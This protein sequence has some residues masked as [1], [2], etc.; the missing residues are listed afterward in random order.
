MSGK[1]LIVGLTGGSGTGKSTVSRVFEREG[2][3]I[4]DYDLISRQVCEKGSDC[5]DEIC[6]IFG[7]G[8]L[9]SDSTLNRK[10]LGAIVFSDGEKL[11]ALN[12]ITH[13]YITLR[14]EE[15]LASSDS[16]RFVLDA[17]LLFEAELEKKCD[18][19]VSVLSGVEK[20]TERIMQRDSISYEYALK[21]INSQKKDE[22]YIEKSDFVIYNNNSVEELNDNTLK[23]IR[24]ITSHSYEGFS[25][26]KIYGKDVF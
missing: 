6:A 19:V 13:K 5:L 8:V 3:E 25:A 21:R 16:E 9:N 23:I 24:D 7:N 14:S 12:T 20:R 11:R 1:K 4:I 10:A 2:F 26:A 17:P 15:I 22:F 18:C